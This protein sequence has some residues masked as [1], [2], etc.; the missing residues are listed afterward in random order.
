[1]KKHSTRF[2]TRA[3]VVGALYAAL[4][5]AFLPYAYGP[6]QIRPAEAL[7]VLPAFFPESIPGLFVGCMIANLGSSAAGVWDVVFGS[8]ITLIAALLSWKLRH[9][10]LVGLP[11]VLL[12]AFGIP[13]ILVLAAGT[14]WS[15]YFTVVLQIAVT[16]TLW[17]YGLGLPLYFYLKKL[18]KK[19][20]HL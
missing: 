20:K 15:A 19:G 7:T 13:L 17:V 11:P 14:P 8:L 5:F 4:T 10:L 12:N 6:L 1:M 2:L 18:Q 3:G 9:P 16:Q